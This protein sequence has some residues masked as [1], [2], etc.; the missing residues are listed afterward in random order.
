M[1]GGLKKTAS[2]TWFGLDTSRVQI[3]LKPLISLSMR[4]NMNAEPSEVKIVDSTTMP[5]CPT[6]SETCTYLN[7]P[8]RRLQ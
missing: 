1:T 6:G 7:L 2:E 3:E 4:A 8:E 5:R